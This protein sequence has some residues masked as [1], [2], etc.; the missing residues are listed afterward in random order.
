MYLYVYDG[1]P[2]MMLV[3]MRRVTGLFRLLGNL[4]VT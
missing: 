4:I 2:I 1:A 3:V